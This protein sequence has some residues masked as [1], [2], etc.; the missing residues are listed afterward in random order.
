MNLYVN[1]KETNLDYIKDCFRNKD[2]VSVEDILYALDEALENIEEMKKAKEK[3]G[4]ENEIEFE[5][6]LLREKGLI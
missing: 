6:M 4:Q 3:E 2:L 1:L 5:E